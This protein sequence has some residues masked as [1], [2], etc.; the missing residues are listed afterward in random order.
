MAAFAEIAEC[1]A[2]WAEL[3]LNRTAFEVVPGVLSLVL[4][5]WL[6]TKIEVE[7]AGRGFGRQRGRSRPVGT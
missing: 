5:A 3:R 4:F 2:F 7:F 1:F 6:L